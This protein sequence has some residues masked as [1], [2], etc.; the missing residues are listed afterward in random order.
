MHAPSLPLSL[1]LSLFLSF[2][3]SLFLSFS[4]SLFLSFY[5][6]LFLSLSLSFPDLEAFFLYVVLMH[7]RISTLQVIQQ[8]SRHFSLAS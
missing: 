6:S 4:L 8:L 5:L 1:S 3:L 7:K 2:S